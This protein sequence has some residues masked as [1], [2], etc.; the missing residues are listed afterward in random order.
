MRRIDLPDFLDAEAVFLVV[1]AFG[2]IEAADQLLCQAAARALGEEGVFGAQ[3]HAAG[4]ARIRLALATDAHV[5][6]RDTDDPAILFEEFRCRKSRIDLDTEFLRLAAEIARHIAE[7]A[8]EIA[9]VVH[10]LGHEHVGQ[11]H[12]ARRA[13]IEELVLGHLRLERPVAIIAPIRQQRIEAAW[14]R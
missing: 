7:R 3:L 12:A 6:R 5:A 9:V 14:D 4:E 8:D 13:E 11:P 2:E 1:A 10:E